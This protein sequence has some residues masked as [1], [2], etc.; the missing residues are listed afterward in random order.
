M[1]FEFEIEKSIIDS[2]RKLILKPTNEI[3]NSLKA[4]FEI[5][6]EKYPLLI[7]IITSKYSINLTWID[8]RLP[9][10][11]SESIS[12]LF[13]ENNQF[14]NLII[15]YFEYEYNQ[16]KY[17]LGNYTIPKN[18]QILPKST[19][20]GKSA[21]FELLSLIAKELIEICGD[22]KEIQFHYKQY[23]KSKRETI[24]SSNINEILNTLNNDWLAEMKIGLENIEIE[25]LRMRLK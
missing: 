10:Y 13:D 2:E 20:I 16:N 9:L 19:I 1:K 18:S 25:L 5:C 22:N 15:Y 8:E 6:I 23:L 4:L 24:T 17:D 12:L 14:E 11:Q 21:L 7:K 3:F